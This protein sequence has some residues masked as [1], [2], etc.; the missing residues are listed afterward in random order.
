[1]ES[2]P[3]YIVANAS[4]NDFAFFLKAR[5]EVAIKN[6]T[7]DYE[8]K[9]QG[10]RVELEEIRKGNGES[11]VILKHF[12]YIIE[13]IVTLKCPRKGCCAPF[14]I[15]P[16]FNDGCGDAALT[17]GVCGCGFCA[18]CFLDC[19]NDANHHVSGCRPGLEPR[20]FF[21]GKKDFDKVHGP[22]RANLI[23]DYLAKQNLKVN[24]KEAII[25]SLKRFS[26]QDDNIFF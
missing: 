14:I 15:P 2:I 3:D 17:C 25:N 16:D 4:S 18:W 6:V 12:S 21:A 1:M 9:I 11:A 24:I 22:R 13:E 20:G 23:K 10:L 7:N 5:E 26:L 8:S 19:G